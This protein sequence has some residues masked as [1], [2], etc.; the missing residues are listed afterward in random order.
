MTQILRAEMAAVQNVFRKFVEMEF[1][2][3]MKIVMMGTILLVMV[4]TT[5]ANL[6]FVETET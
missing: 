3:S 5:S 6:K 1:K 4:V 2:I